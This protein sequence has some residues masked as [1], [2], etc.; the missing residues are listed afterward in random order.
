M[1]ERA[2]AA[3]RGERGLDIYYAHRG[4]A[5]ECLA[6][7]LDAPVDGQLRALAG[8]TWRPR[9][10]C[11]PA[12]LSDRVDHLDTDVVYLVSTRGVTVY[13][14][15]W[16]GFA[17]PADRLTAGVLVRVETPRECRAL[18]AM[19]RFWKDVCHEAIGLGWVDATLARDLFALA[20]RVYCPPGRI[21]A[22]GSSL[23]AE[24]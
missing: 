11:E 4:G 17:W 20:L 21:R 10:R 23:G 24:G 9:G 15:V 1:G 3:V 6:Q 14:P 2:L 8:V 16:L 13:L 18:R 19:V 7:V 5:E 12:T 22:S